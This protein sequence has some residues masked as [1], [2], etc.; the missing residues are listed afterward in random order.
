MAGRRD[1]MDAQVADDQHVAIV[2]PE[3][4][5][6]RGG[7]MAH[8]YLSIERLA[9]L[10]RRGEMVS[11]SVCVDGIPDG[12]AVLCG[13]AAITLDGA[14]LG[15]D[16]GGDVGLRAAENVRAAAADFDGFQYHDGALRRGF[17]TGSGGRR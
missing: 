8:D 13:D 10:A 1:R 17:V 15:V 4:D 16:D 7:E 12:E 5:E 14:D 9:D 6:G 3:I 11:V 2:E